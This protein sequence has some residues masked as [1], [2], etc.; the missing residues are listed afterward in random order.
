MINSLN[1]VDSKFV[2]L[3]VFFWFLIILSLLIQGC[4]ST[5]SV[6]QR[7]D[8]ASQIIHRKNWQSSIIA[9]SKFDLQSYKKPINTNFTYDVMTIYIE[10][11]GHAWLNV[12]TPS[13]NPTPI[14]PVALR[15]ALQDPGE[16]VAYLARP[17][18][19]VRAEKFR[20][21][22][23]SYW[24]NRRFAVEV[25]IS[26]NEAINQLKENFQ[27]KKIILVGHSG[28]ATL[29]LLSAAQRSDVIKIISV[30]GNVDTD[31]WVKYHAL[32]PLIGSLN[33][34]DFTDTLINIP[35]VLYVGDKDFI[36]PP[37]LI[38]G[39]LSKFPKENY[40]K[41]INIKGYGHVCCWA[42]DWPIL[43]DD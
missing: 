16:V 36:V 10:G 26:I 5:T 12:E 40:P 8:N 19:Y 37:N 7:I 30:A 9:T 43:I 25:V 1:Y 24:T 28:G 18:Q 27:A 34:S 32:S 39:Y 23:Q 41:V 14:E 15:L 6:T 22:D 3:R 33:P 13:I 31:A 11:D 20:N 4:A 17:C 35:Q 21:C 38:Q 2:R 29:A 42:K